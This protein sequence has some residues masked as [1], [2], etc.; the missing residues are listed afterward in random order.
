MKLGAANFLPSEKGADR[1]DD[2]EL[3]VAETREFDPWLF[4]QSTKFH[5]F[6][7]I[8]TAGVYLLKTNVMKKVTFTSVLL[9]LAISPFFGGSRL[10]GNDDAARKS[11]LD[12]LAIAP[13]GYDGCER[14]SVENSTLSASSVVMLGKVEFGAFDSFL[15]TT[16]LG[17]LSDLVL[18]APMPIGP[19]S[20][21]VVL[22]Y[23]DRT[24]LKKTNYLLSRTRA[25]QVRRHFADLSLTHRLG[26]KTAIVPM[27]EEVQLCRH[28]YSHNRVAEIWLLNL[29]QP[30]K[31]DHLTSASHIH[32]AP[33]IR[34]HQ[35]SVSKHGRDMEIV[36]HRN[37]AGRNVITIPV[38][39]VTYEDGKTYVVGKNSPNRDFERWEVG[40]GRSDGIYVEA[41]RGVFPGD[42]IVVNSRAR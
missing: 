9:L 1:S 6:A 29:A 26:L 39:S 15:G 10:R 11:L 14:R 2:L 25:E 3:V 41:L 42:T 8:A 37:I 19:D 13:T 24:G 16:A 20:L 7:Q 5:F 22:G 4:H 30:G 38:D 23:T 35:A 17:E 40:L 33:A 36:Q 34:P 27:G 31:C 18:H 28:G 21:I 32:S 12:R